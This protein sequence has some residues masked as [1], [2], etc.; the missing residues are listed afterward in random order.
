MFKNCEITKSFQEEVSQK[1]C[2]IF[3]LDVKI[4]T[5]RQR[6]MI[7]THQIKS[8]KCEIDELKLRERHQKLK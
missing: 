1:F 2:K 3:G 8:R 5:N 6:E 7:S 4:W